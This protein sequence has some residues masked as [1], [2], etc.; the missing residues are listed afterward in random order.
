MSIF[1]FRLVYEGRGRRRKVVEFNGIPDMEWWQLI[2]TP[3]AGAFQRRRPRNQYGFGTIDQSLTNYWQFAAVEL[4]ESTETRTAIKRYSN[5]KATILLDIHR[6]CQAWIKEFYALGTRTAQYK[7]KKPLMTWVF[8]LAKN[9]KFCADFLT[10]GKAQTAGE[11]RWKMLRQDIKKLGFLKNGRAPLKALDSERWSE[12]NLGGSN[13]QHFEGVGLHGEWQRSDEKYLFAFTRKNASTISAYK[14]HYV[15][16]RDLWKYQVVVQS[17]KL[18]KIVA[19]PTRRARLRLAAI[20]CAGK[21]F[22]LLRNG[23]LY[24]NIREVDRDH[25]TTFHHSSIPAGRAV[26]MA[27]DITIQRGQLTEI[28]NG[29]GHYKP[30][31]KHLVNAL[32]IMEQKGVDF[33]RT[34]VVLLVLIPDGRGNLVPTIPFPTF[35]NIELFRQY[36]QQQE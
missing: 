1:E 34:R 13:P 12:A 15:K 30:K 23:N 18:C 11:L 31:P 2:T 7:T 33:S 9:A 27:G 26:I 36:A 6:E 16:K 8:C 4:D 35:A 21:H 14:V 10:G 20:T 32:E 19:P 3:A 25:D 29:S 22:V 24:A 17:G 28:G 5:I